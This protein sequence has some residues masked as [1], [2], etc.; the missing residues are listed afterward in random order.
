VFGIGTTN[1]LRSCVVGVSPYQARSSMPLPRRKGSV[2][3]MRTWSTIMVPAVP[4]SSVCAIRGSRSSADR[5]AS[6]ALMPAPVSKM[7]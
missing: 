7:K 2:L 1:A 4:A 5:P 6:T 3:A